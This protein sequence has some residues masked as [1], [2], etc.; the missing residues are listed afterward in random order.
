M[1]SYR[2]PGVYVNEVPSGARAIGRVGTSSAGFVGV[3]PKTDAP[4]DTVVAIDNWTQFATTFVGDAT[5]GSH[6]SSAVFGFF[7]NGGSRCYVVNIGDGGSLTGTARNPTGVTLF[8]AVDDI[9][10][11][12]AP[13]FAGPADHAALLAHCE[14]P[15]RQDRVAIL[16]TVE[17]VPDIAALLEVATAGVPRGD[18]SDKPEETDEP[19]AAGGAGATGGA[20]AAAGPTGGVGSA[21]G[22]AGGGGGSGRR[23]SGV[24]PPTSADGYAA[25]YFPWLVTVDPVTGAQVTTP[26]SGHLAGVWARTDGTRGVHKAPAGIGAPVVGA[27]DLTRRVSQGEQEL[28]NPAGINCIRFFSGEGIRV[29]GARTLAPEASEF[30]YIPVRRLTNLIKESILAGTRWAVFEPN[31]QPLWAALRRDVSAFLDLVWRDGAL[32]GATPE[33]AF[34]VKCDAETNPA[35]VRDAGMVVTVVGIAPVKPAEFVVFNIMQSAD[36]AD[37]SATGVLR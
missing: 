8:E 10:I 32:V 1:P 4:R 33:Q 18:A 28:L 34:F 27:I 35:Q 11:V 7:D 37:L 9:S 29:W 19:G 14:H 13:G 2:A 5:T 21:A 30:R 23:A 36:A 6:L 31:H 16:D 24:R 20:A 15:L 22:S 17:Q 12:A 3:A 25:T 26:P